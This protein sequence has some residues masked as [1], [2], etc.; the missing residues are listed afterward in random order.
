MG[1]VVISGNMG[2]P[3]L[4]HFCNERFEADC[5]LWA[6]P[7]T[8]PVT[9]SKLESHPKKKH[10]GIWL[11]NLAKNMIASQVKDQYSKDTQTLKSTHPL[12][13]LV[14]APSLAPVAQ[15]AERTCFCLP[16]SR[17]SRCQMVSIGVKFK[18]WHMLILHTSGAIRTQVGNKPRESPCPVSKQA[19]PAAS[20]EMN[21]ALEVRRR[22][23]DG[24]RKWKKRGEW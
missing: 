23:E 15:P 1:I 10:S 14:L 3:W 13:P 22:G 5:T 9:S 19:H 6:V 7:Q 24:S 18:G 21:F 12:E 2:C 16:Y 4:S 8:V 11:V 17:F 20:L